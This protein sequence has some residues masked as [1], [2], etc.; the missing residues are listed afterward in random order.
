MEG[1][2]KTTVDQIAAEAGLSRAS[3]FRYLPPKEDVVLG[4]LEELGHQQTLP[5]QGP[6]R[7]HLHR[8]RCQ[9]RS[10]IRDRPPAGRARR[11]GGAGYPQRA[12]GGGCGRP[13]KDRAAGRRRRIPGARPCRPRFGKG[14]LGRNFEGWDSGGRAHQQRRGDVPAT[15]ADLTGFRIPVREQSSGPLRVDSDA[16]RHDP[17]GPGRASGHG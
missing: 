5:D 6:I 11:T 13:A 4:S 17:A 15:P 16:V 12:E 10:R 2:E 14:P 3:F 1:F 8:H 9:Q 7:P